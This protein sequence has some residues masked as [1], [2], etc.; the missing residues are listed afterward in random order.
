M[1]RK[2][3]YKAKPATSVLNREK[4]QFLDA[5]Q[6]KNDRKDLLMSKRGLNRPGMD[7]KPIE[8]D[9]DKENKKPK[10]VKETGKLGIHCVM[11]AKQ[12][13]ITRCHTI[14]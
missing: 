13:C 4:R 6:R 3:A 12:A 1:D 10:I 11:L 7:K 5:K 9:K 2:N 8:G 14:D